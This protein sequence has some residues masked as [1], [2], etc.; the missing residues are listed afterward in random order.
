MPRLHLLFQSCVNYLLK[1]RPIKLAS[2]EAPFWHLGG[3]LKVSRG[4]AQPIRQCLFRP[5]WESPEKQ[6][7][8]IFD[9]SI[10]APPPVNFRFCSGRPIIDS[11]HRYNTFIT[12][13]SWPM[14]WPLMNAG[15][16]TS[17]SSRHKKTHPNNFALHLV[18]L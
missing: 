15:L 8:R 2:L 18:I 3:I 13:S 7:L 1:R 11:C 9:N 10:I 14:S 6:R 16:V 12:V 4:V 5:G 17:M